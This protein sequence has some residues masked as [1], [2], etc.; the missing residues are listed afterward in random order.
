DG[1]LIPTTSVGNSAVFALH[2]KELIIEINT[3]QPM[4]LEGLHDSYEPEAIGVRQPIPLVSPRDRI[5]TTGIPI[6][7]SKVKGIVWTDQA[8]SPSPIEPP[9]AETEIMAGHLLDFLRGEVQAGR[10]S[11][12]LP[13]LLSGVGSVANAVLH[14]LID[15]EFEGL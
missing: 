12:N 13:P 3:A 8:D 15:S 1:L 14:G 5:G 2:A 9:D 10:L 7:A 6:D 11:K 4:E